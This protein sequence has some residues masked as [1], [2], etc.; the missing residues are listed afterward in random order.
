MYKNEI[1][2]IYGNNNG[3]ISLVKMN[4]VSQ[5]INIKEIRT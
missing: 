2:L 5:E 3:R 1:E 4:L